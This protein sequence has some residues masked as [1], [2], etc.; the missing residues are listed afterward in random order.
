MKDK[1]IQNAFRKGFTLIELMIVIVIL[2][3]LMGTV[4][5]RLT[6]AQGR[7]RDAGRA[8]DLVAISQ[9][10][11]TYRDDYGSFPAAATGIYECL[12]P[13][14]AGSAASKI[15]EY[16]QSKKVPIAPSAQQT[17]KIGTM[18]CKDGRYMYM[19]LSNR[20]TPLGAFM[21]VTDVETYQKANMLASQPLV[22]GVVTDL[23][24]T[25]EVLNIKE[26]NSLA[27][28]KAVDDVSNQNTLY[29]VTGQ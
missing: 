25:T 5:P 23:K 4:L 20:Q 3:I 29:F 2:G 22:N 7:A 11:I 26:V 28:L 6:G 9:A 10:L 17:T 12:D 1:S 14:V 13:T 15:A 27:A 16:M 24:S 8:A 19:P 21:L 18:E